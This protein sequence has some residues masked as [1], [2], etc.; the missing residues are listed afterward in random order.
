MLFPLVR[1]G[2]EGAS[3]LSTPYI[4]SERSFTRQPNR[5]A[6]ARSLRATIDSTPITLPQ[7]DNPLAGFFA[8]QRSGK[9]RDRMHACHMHGSQRSARGILLIYGRNFGLYWN[10][11]Y[12]MLSEG[13]HTSNNNNN[14]NN[15]NVD[16]RSPSP[17]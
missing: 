16:T 8:R 3:R 6:R 4:C 13:K 10:G 11:I 14:N 1:L 9:K 5:G 2:P 17:R 7:A 15:N 12:A